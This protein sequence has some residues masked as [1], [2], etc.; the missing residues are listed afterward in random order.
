MHTDGI[1][2]IFT[3]IE[4]GT[5]KDY[6]YGHLNVKYAFSMEL[7]DIGKY[8]FMLPTQLIKPTA[9]EAFEGI[10]AMVLNMKFR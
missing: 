6:V 10:K 9:K 8:G 2:L 4:S 1:R 3:D 7:R 5:T